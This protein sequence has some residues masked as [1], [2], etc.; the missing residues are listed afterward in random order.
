[1][2]E[3]YITLS[4]ETHLF[5]SRIMKEHSFFL[6]AGFPCQKEN[7]IQQADAFRQQ[8]EQ[9]LADHVLRE[10]NHYIRILKCSQMQEDA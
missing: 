1:M 4:L 8:F 9:F 3:N 2:I 6:E 7:W 5:F 10:A